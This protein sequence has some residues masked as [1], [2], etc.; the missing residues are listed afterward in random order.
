M[1][2]SRPTNPRLNFLRKYVDLLESR[3]TI[4]GTQFKFGIDPLL[5]F[6]PIIGSYSGLIL[7]FVFIILAHRQGVSGKVK[8]LMFRNLI[9][10]FL[11]GLLPVVGYVT[12]FYYKSN[13]KNMRLLEDHILNE[14]HRG[15]GWSLIILFILI[16][17]T[18][19][20]FS[21]AFFFWALNYIFSL[22]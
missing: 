19:L 8:V 12:D 9:T 15:S 22:L 1:N 17:L 18:I 11:L 20:I 16:S 6:I 4:P 7:G 10:D 5:N 14:K 21:F 2:T 3:F 13:L